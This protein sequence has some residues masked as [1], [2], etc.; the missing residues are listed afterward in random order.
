MLLSLSA[1]AFS[2]RRPL[3]LCFT[4]TVVMLRPLA[5]SNSSWIVWTPLLTPISLLLPHPT[6]LSACWCVA[7]CRL[8]W[9]PH[10]SQPFHRWSV[11][12]VQALSTWLKAYSFTI[13]S[14]RNAPYFLIWLEYHADRS[15]LTFC[16]AIFCFR[17]YCLQI[18]ID[19][20]CIVRTFPSSSSSCTYRDL[21]VKTGHYI[22]THA[23]ASIAISSRC[24]H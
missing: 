7:C 21:W 23:N 11:L 16:Q 1:H 4:S 3:I 9:L 15:T 5:F 22:F 20:L 6:L 14:R 18:V 12:K 10:S 17:T 24:M 13:R 8:L 2:T 19:Q